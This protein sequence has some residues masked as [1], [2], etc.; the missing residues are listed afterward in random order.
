[1][2]QI[3]SQ[4]ILELV[5]VRSKNSVRYRVGRAV[6]EYYEAKLEQRDPQ[7]GMS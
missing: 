5:G 3:D 6:A 4:K 7:A 1:M 2:T